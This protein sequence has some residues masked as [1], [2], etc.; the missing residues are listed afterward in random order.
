MSTIATHITECREKQPYAL[1]T[2]HPPTHH[3]TIIMTNN[4]LARTYTYNPFLTV[5]QTSS[6]QLQ[7]KQY[8]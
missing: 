6:T 1:D 4:P 7:L 2:V 3:G 5:S 8:C